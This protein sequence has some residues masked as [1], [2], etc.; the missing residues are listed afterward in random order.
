MS[1]GNR[2]SISRLI[3]VPAIITLG[4]TILRLVG[5]LQNWPSPLFGKAAGG[6]GAIVGIS[7]LPFIFGPY[8]AV[9]LIK[10]GIRPASVGKTI[11]FGVL[12]FVLMGGGGTLAFALSKGSLVLVLA[13]LIV[14]A[15]GAAV[16]F[17]AWSSLAKTLMAYAFSARIPVAIIMYF[18]MRGNWG[19]HYDAV[20][21]EVGAM[22]LIA[23]WA[24]LGLAPQ[25]VLW[26]AYTMSVGALFG[27]IAAAIKKSG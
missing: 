17:P 13:G 8:F 2:L 19:T 7:W 23:K 27:G 9:K 11:G 12:G 15:A 21:P 14:I 22:S 10:A 3:L 20:P 25:L 24:F 4:I 1:S 16:Q 6:G 26:I 18:A 5:E